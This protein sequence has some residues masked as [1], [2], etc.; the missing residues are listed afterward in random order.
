MLSGHVH[1]PNQLTSSLSGLKGDQR[2]EVREAQEPMEERSLRQSFLVA[3][4]WEGIKQ[5]VPPHQREGKKSLKWYVKWY[6]K[7]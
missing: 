1:P 5:E 3:G 6:V 7:S 4:G 2:E